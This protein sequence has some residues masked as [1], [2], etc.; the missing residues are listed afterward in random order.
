MKEN[1]ES[2][3]HISVEQR[4]AWVLNDINSKKKQAEKFDGRDWIVATFEGLMIR[5]LKYGNA[6][7]D[8]E[9]KT[10]RPHELTMRRTAQQNKPAAQVYE[11]LQEGLS[12][13]AIALKLK[14]SV[15]EVQ[16]LELKL[17]RLYKSIK[18][19]AGEID[20]GNPQPTT[21]KD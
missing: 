10:Y 4:M 17:I 19:R 2:K 7:T 11:L 14:Y 18:I 12:T 6:M 20:A 16:K 15:P 8:E 3:Q 1:C 5:G 13:E 9:I 21:A